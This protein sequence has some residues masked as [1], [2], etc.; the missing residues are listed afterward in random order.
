MFR[1]HTCGELRSEHVG[2]EVTISGWADTI[3]ISGKIGFIILR[4][5]YGVT[6]CFVGSKFA[7]QLKTIRKES[8]LQIKGKVNARPENQVKKEMLTGA[9]EV[10]VL[11]LKLL[12]SADPLP[13][14]ETA[15]EDTRLKYR[16]LDLRGS[17]LQDTIKRRHEMIFFMRSFLSAKGF[18][19]ITTPILTKS[20]PEGARDYL[21]PSRVYPGSF[22]ALPQSPQQYKQLLMLSGFDKYFQIAP[23]FRD[24]DA[25]ADRAPGEFY[26][27]DMEMSFVH[28][29]DVLSITEELFIKMIHAVFPEK[30][31]QEIPFPRIKYADAVKNYGIDKPDLRKDKND[32]N[33]LAFCWV[34]D[35]PLFEEELE[36]GHCA[37]KHH[38]FTQPHEEDIHFLD[39]D[40]RKARSYQHD[41]VLNGFEVGGGS[42][43]IHDAALQAKI[44]DLIG[45]DEEH[46][47]YFNHMLEAFRYGVPPHGGVA[48][49][50]D[51]TLMV[52]MGE[53]SIRDV[54]A[55]PKNKEAR[56][57]MMDAPAEVLP[58][59]LDELSIEIK[60]PHKKTEH[61]AEHE[62][63]H[64]DH[65]KPEHTHATEHAH[66]AEHHEAHTHKEHDAK[67][68]N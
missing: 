15:T 31:I 30:K 63:E 28:Q 21:V 17:K 48:P 27:L 8:V 37:P 26:Q 40:P 18:Y 61:K 33:V 7:E 59:Q 53:K 13:L 56:D 64:S 24:E 62:K 6:Q 14:D 36:K 66:H 4:D 25:R 5:R 44:F 68:K 29:E 35:F 41:L 12:S 67:K 65:H 46:K 38:M 22:F 11:D 16:Y 10:E 60:K 2:Q 9:V 32:P 47:K 34:I 3:R 54:V 52:I 42:I 39:S 23:C 58:G 45:F 20:T 57:V 43:R 1:T 19:E 51:R 55:F 49:G 50:V